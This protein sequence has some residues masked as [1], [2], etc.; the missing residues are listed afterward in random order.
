MGFFSKISGKINSKIKSAFQKTSE[1][2]A[3]S[4]KGQ[5]IDETLLNSIE[6][7]L[8]LVD[9]GIETATKLVEKLAGKK[10]QKDVSEIDV[11]SYLAKEIELIMLPY[12]SAFPERNE[13]NS[14]PYVI[15]TIGVNGNGKTT[16][17]AKLANLMKNKGEKVLLVAADTFRAAA[18]DQLKYWA[19]RIGVKIVC[20][21]E[22]ADPA[23][24]VY[25]ALEEAKQQGYDV[26]LV[27]TAGRMQNRGD[28]LDELEKI[29]RVMKKIDPA[30]PHCT[31]LILDGITGQ[32]TH[33][34]VEIFQDKI[35][36][37]GVIVTKLDGSAKGGSL[38]AL[39]QK[40]GI[41]IMGIGV[42]E[43]IEDLKEFSAEEY[44]KGIMGLLD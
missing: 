36:I 11:R 31:L 41:K 32:A 18:V 16:T 9:A 42:G 3:I 1:Q 33:S 19:D 7:S 21:K 44:A 43:G 4:I 38:I 39:V 30:A 22:N 13:L 35:G 23:G 6:D 20:G 28:L 26:V 14:K 5:K 24:L 25:E 40:Y 8:I 2:I 37:D 29:K 15:L 27:D 17:I 34:Q 12:V 10:F